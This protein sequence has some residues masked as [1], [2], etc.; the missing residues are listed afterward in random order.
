MIDKEIRNSFEQELV[1]NGYNIFKSSF[2]NSIKGFQKRIKDEKGTKYFINIWHYNH[3][4]QLERDDIKKEDTYMADS[5]FK[6]N[7]EGQDSTCDIQFTGDFLPNEHREITT[8]KDI[9]DFFE[10]FFRK[11]KPD[12]YER[13]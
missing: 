6:F 2:R 4:E 10:T 8:L 9:E 5:Q 12:Y 7:K 11:M 13:N 3:A 1:D